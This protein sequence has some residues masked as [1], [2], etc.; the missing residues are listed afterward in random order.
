MITVLSTQ[1]M[2]QISKIRLPT[3][4][5]VSESHSA[6]VVERQRWNKGAI[7]LVAREAPIQDLTVRMLNKVLKIREL[8]K[9]RSF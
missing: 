1:V 7:R 9:S 6:Q 8:S 3:Q 2:G 4:M 5:Q